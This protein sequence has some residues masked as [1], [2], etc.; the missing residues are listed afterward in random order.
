MAYEIKR[1]NLDFKLGSVGIHSES[2]AKLI[3]K[4]LWSAILKFLILENRMVKL[5]IITAKNI[6]APGLLVMKT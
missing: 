3:F 4:I 1:E 2:F 6:V 5:R